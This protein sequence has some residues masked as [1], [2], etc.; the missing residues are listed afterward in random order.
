LKVRRERS[1]GGGLGFGHCAHPN[2]LDSGAELKQF[3]I[4]SGRAPQSSNNA[5]GTSIRHDSS[6]KAKDTIEIH[7]HNRHY[8]KPDFVESEGKIFPCHSISPISASFAT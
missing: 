7:Q 3:P 5:S 4:Q 2:W 1:C 6:R 8:L